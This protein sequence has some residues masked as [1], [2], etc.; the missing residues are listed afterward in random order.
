MFRAYFLIALTVALNLS[1]SIAA[2]ANGL[3][4]VEGGALK[5]SRAAPEAGTVVTYAVLT[6]AYTVP[7]DRSTLSPDNCGAMHSFASIVAQ[8]PG[9]SQ[10]LAKAE[11]RA[12]FAVW[13]AVADITF[14]E[15]EDI[16]RANIIV[17]A[18]DK[19]EGRAYANLSYRNQGTPHAAKA[20]GKSGPDV[21]VSSNEMVRDTAVDIEQ[22]YVCLTPQS[23]WKAGFDGNL[24]VYDLRHTFTHEI[25]HAIGLDHPG[26][27]G[28]I[29][30]YRYDERVR[31]LQPSDIAAVQK[32]YGPR[33]RDE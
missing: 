31:R 12:A 19:P 17:G 28:A 18:A 16:S 6:G 23:R 29:M 2:R 26:S 25:G 7:G 5:W 24:N 13:E 20:L 11:L 21:L 8:S 4:Q 14:A 1:G 15:V 3:L 33:R 22:A 9:I 10:D 30:A 32:L 27:S